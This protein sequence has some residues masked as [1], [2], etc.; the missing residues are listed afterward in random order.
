M[1]VN[2][3]QEI[4]YVLYQVKYEIE[5]FFKDMKVLLNSIEQQSQ[6]QVGIQSCCIQ[7]VKGYEVIHRVKY[8]HFISKDIAV[9]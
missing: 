5:K 9:A 7:H 6:Y 2:W 3:E 8:L 1:D 4:K